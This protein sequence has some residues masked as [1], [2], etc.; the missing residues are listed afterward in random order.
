MA[1]ATG[2]GPLPDDPPGELDVV[3]DLTVVQ[4]GGGLR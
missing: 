1:A 4:V 2:A 3:E